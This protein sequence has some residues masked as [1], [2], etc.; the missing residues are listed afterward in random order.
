MNNSLNKTHKNLYNLN[1]ES[2]CKLKKVNYLSNNRNLNKRNPLFK[3]NL[4]VNPGVFELIIF[5][6]DTNL[7]KIA[8]DLTLKY[9]LNSDKF[10]KLK[11]ILITNVEKYNEDNKLI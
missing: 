1:T 4:E 5:Y 6:S 10:S 3:L 11:N 2:S 8:Y 7:D 9:N